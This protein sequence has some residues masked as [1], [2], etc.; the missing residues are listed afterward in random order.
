MYGGIVQR[1]HTHGTIAT[2]NDK[3]Q[4]SFFFQ[5]LLSLFAEAAN[6]THLFLFLRSMDA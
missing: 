1:T 6:C 4:R 5:F 3:M 2:N